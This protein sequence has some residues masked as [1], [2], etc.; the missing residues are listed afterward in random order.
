DL[1][2]ID[3]HKKEFLIFDLCGNFEYFQQ[4]VR[5]ADSKP[6]DSLATQIF[7][8]RLTLYQKLN[9]EPHLTELRAEIGDRLHAYIA[10]MEPQNFI[11]RRHLKEVEDFSERERWAEL[12]PKDIRILQE[13][14]SQLPH[15]LP[16]E[17]PVMKRFDLLCFQIQLA[18]LQNSPK[19][20]LLR[21]KVRDLLD[22]LAQKRTIPMVKAQLPLIE[23][24]GKAEWW[25][26][27]TLPMVESLR[28]NLR[29]LMQF[30]DR[31]AEAIVYT[32]F[33]DQL[34]DIDEAEVPIQQTGFSSQQYRKKVETYIRDNKDHIAIAK[35]RRNLPL[36]ETDLNSLETML[37]TEAGLE[38]REKF[39]ALFTEAGL[40]SREKFTAACLGEAN[41]LPCF[42]RSMV[43]LDREAAKK[44]FAQYLDSQQFNANQIRFI[45]Q[46][47][48]LLTQQGMVDPSQFYEPPFTD[49]HG[50]GLDGVFSDTDANNILAIARSFNQTIEV[51]FG[52]NA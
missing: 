23:A 42:I 34:G 8:A 39:T 20:T 6:A 47:I 21:D 32:D 38:S 2:G 35:L 7:K 14:L 9:N 26:N 18:L 31:Q 50:E 17:N 27:V 4:Q 24:I 22:N 25:Q 5:E 45:E 52:L 49:F 37:F 10:S 15:G 51:K 3:R 12:S 48:D 19:L 29:E 36:T 28:K 16:R 44:A 43:G 11:V 40:E 13:T 33:Q 30:I 46:I 41:N 1:F